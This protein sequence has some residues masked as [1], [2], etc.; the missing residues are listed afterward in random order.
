MNFFSRGQKTFK[1]EKR[2][3]EGT[4]RFGLHKQAFG[5]LGSTNVRDLVV[6]PEGEDLNEWFAVNTIEFYNRVNVIYAIISESCTSTTCPKMS[7][8]P[9]YIER[10]LNW[11]EEIVENPK[12][13]PQTENEKY[14]KSYKKYIK[15]IFKRLLRV[16]AHV[17]ANHFDEMRELG[18]DS[19]LN[20]CYKHFLFFILHFKLIQKTELAP[21]QSINKKIFEREKSK[22][23]KK[24]KK[25][26]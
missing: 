3:K 22:R 26:K 24:S 11:I 17:Y 1:K 5:T 14:P 15:M 18:A 20:S 16:F 7:A 9:E 23:K 25:K 8:A 21:L 2:F 10:L 6:L 13:F 19:H 4:I 12:I